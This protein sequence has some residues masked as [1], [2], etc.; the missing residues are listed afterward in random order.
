MKQREVDETRG[1]MGG[2]RSAGTSPRA[3]GGLWLTE[4]LRDI[5]DASAQRRVLVW[6]SLAAATALTL[7]FAYIAWTR[8]TV[9]PAEQ[10]GFWFGL[11]AFLAVPVVMR[12]TASTAAGSFIVLVAMSGLVIVPAYYQGGAS[13]IFTI[14]FLLIPLM[15]G[16][17]LGHRF[18]V[19]L[20]ILGVGVT[21]AL[22]GL[23]VFGLLPKPSKTIDPVPAWL[24]LVMVIAFSATVGAVSSKAFL[25]SSRRIREATLAEAAKSRALEAAIEGIAEVDGRGCFRSVNHSFAAMHGCS[26]EDLVGSLAAG[27]VHS[28]DRIELDRASAAL[29]DGEKAEVTLRGRRPDGGYFFESLVLVG[30]PDGEPGDHYRF[31][32]DVTR[33]KALSEQLNQ[34]SKME[35]IGRLAGGIAHDFNN[36]LMTILTATERLGDQIEGSPRAERARERLDWGDTAARRAAVLT[37]QL[38]DFSHVQAPEYTTIAVHESLERLVDVLA[39]TLGFSIDVVSEFST[40]PL[41]TVGDVARFESGLMNLAVNARDAMPEGGTLCFRT[42]QCGLDPD[43]PQFA[44]FHLESDSFVSIEVSDTGVGISTE[45]LEKIF[46]P[47]FTTKMMGKGTGLGLSLF[48]SYTREVGGVLKVDSEPGVGTTVRIYL[49][50][51]SPPAVAV[52][53]QPV[54]RERCRGATVLLAEDEPIVAE[55]IR[56][57]LTECG[58]S[59]IECSDGRQAL[60]SL[61]EAGDSVDLVLL[62]YRMPNLNGIE[63][64]DAIHA[65]SPGLPVILMSG[66]IKASQLESLRARGLRSVLRKP[67]SRDELL[68]EVS[69]ALDDGEVAS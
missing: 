43:D 19:L 40:T 28:D 6:V 41:H 37:R 24:N 48:Y 65:A 12:V 66:A 29:A 31:A 11:A 67:C 25:T 32:R 7:E 5:F 15:A 69:A 46:D 44:A 22:F 52:K 61:E 27:W 14:W 4:P 50:L 26:I 30:N 35:A 62:D 55:L 56:G 20:G 2:R 21:S 49:P 58:Y 1:E 59:V 64:F 34:S 53:S 10:F 33:Q 68:R 38:L 36:L 23:E 13:A 57:I 17:L 42:G 18:A 54:A 16:F 51:A 9:G 47:F 3:G 45:T 60:D 63:V 39:P 8:Q